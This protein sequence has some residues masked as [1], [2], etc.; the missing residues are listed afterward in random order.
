MDDTVHF[1]VLTRTTVGYSYP[2]TKGFIDHVIV[3]KDLLPWLLGGSV[4]TE[5]ARKYVTNYTTTTSDH[6][7]VTARFMFVP[8]PQKSQPR[9][10][11]RP[12]ME[13]FHFE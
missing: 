4:R 1:A 2:A 8:R 7:P 3:S 6:L 13:I 12:H 9:L 5:D 11:H 10:F